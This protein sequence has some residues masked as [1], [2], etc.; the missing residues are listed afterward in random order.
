MTE[1]GEGMIEQALMA[2]QPRRNVDRSL[3]GRGKGRKEQDETSSLSAPPRSVSVERTA[4]EQ[5]GGVKILV[6]EDDPHILESLS[7]AF[8]LRW[9][10]VSLV[11]TDRGG[12][13]VEMVDSEAPDVVILDLGLPDINGLEVLRQVR[14]F[15]AVPIIILTAMSEDENKARAM[16]LGAN[17]FVLKPFRQAQFLERIKALLAR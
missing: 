11:S 8:E 3:K 16:E 7:L 2:R 17:D 4:M 9:P 13:G 10:E 12:K 6:I 15:S 5:E 14:L 1:R